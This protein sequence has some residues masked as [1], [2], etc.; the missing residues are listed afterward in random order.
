[1]EVNNTKKIMKRYNRIASIYD[2]LEKPMENMAV[3][4]LREE[5]FKEVSGK[6]LEVGVG[7]GKN[8]E[9]Y[10]ENAEVTA[11]DFSEKMLNKARRKASIL[12]RNVELL[13]MDAEDMKFNDNTF[14]YIITTCVFCSIPDP[15]KGFSEV[16]RVL[17]PSGK[18]IMI[19]HVRSEGKILG[20]VMDL[21]NPAVVSLM[22]ANINRNTHLNAQK[23]GFE[24]I[25]VTK[26]WK[27]I[28]IKIEI[29]NGK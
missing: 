2:I 17:K 16:K 12:N 23:S 1:M 27:D 8:I 28:V 5:I 19:E 7:T 10:P 18:M 22:G 20:L 14:D 29:Q 15:I 3:G 26:L 25:K 6:V 11:I 21:M 4:K 9:F 13:V 24:N